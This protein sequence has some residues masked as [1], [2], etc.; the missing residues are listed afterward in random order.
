MTVRNMSIVALV[1]GILGLVG[2]L[3][4]I[5]VVKFLAPL[6]P[7]AG[8]VFGALALKRIKAGEDPDSKGL[9]MAGLI[10]GIVAMVL[11]LFAVVCV[12]CSVCVAA[13][14]LGA[15]LAGY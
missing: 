5:D 15:G 7:I 6:F 11:D 8:I 2:G 12:V 14:I 1:C 13:G 9:A 10:L 4:P 3:I